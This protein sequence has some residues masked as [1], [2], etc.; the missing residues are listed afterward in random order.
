M[1]NRENMFDERPFARCSECGEPLYD[2]DTAYVLEE[3][4]YC[5]S[6]VD[7]GLVVCRRED[8]YE[9]ENDYDYE[10]YDE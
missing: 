7:D 8:E 6:C 9:D 2:G 1:K 5:T 3:R 4:Y 10:A